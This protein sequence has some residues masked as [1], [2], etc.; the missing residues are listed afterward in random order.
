VSARAA[1]S[2]L[3]ALHA[4]RAIFLLCN[5]ASMNWATRAAERTKTDLEQVRAD[6]RAGLVPGATLMPTG[7]FALA[8]AQ[9]AGCAYM[10]G[11]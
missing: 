9:N 3:D 8:R 6:V 5:R 1:A 4:R 7:V 10:R 2:L 11:S